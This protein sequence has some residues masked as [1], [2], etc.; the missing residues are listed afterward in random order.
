MTNPRITP[1]DR[2]AIKGGLRR[3]FAR[4]ELHHKIIQDSI[5]DHVDLNRPRVKVWCRC[6]AC[7]G[8]EAKS[9]MVV[10]H[11]LPLIPTSTSFA[12]MLL[13]EVM[14]RLWCE[15]TN[16]Q[17]ICPGCHE[18]KTK[19]EKEERKLNKRKKNAK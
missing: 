12:D 14:N 4:S 10:D 19:L 7:K 11:I 18:A 1:K 13:D 2:N 3:A 5:I 15:V 16:L 17:T 6:N 9:Y 8:P